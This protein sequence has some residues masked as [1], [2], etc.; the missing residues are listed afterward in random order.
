MN[1]EPDEVVGHREDMLKF[2]ID[3]ARS[4]VAYAIKQLR[5]FK[6]HIRAL[7]G[8]DRALE[9]LTGAAV[10]PREERPPTRTELAIKAARERGEA[11]IEHPLVEPE[12][13]DFTGVPIYAGIPSDPVAQ[14]LADLTIVAEEP[15]VKGWQNV[16]T[17]E[18]PP[19]V[20]DSLSP[21]QKREEYYGSDAHALAKSMTQ[22]DV[23]QIRKEGRIAEVLRGLVEEAKK[24]RRP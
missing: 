20:W 10:I 11:V 1:E 6:D 15:D 16:P 24:V 21:A 13:T 22:I 4:D 9:S 14:C 12:Q 19:M 8:L 2:A 3:S 17:A 5:E 23:D 7:D 18:A